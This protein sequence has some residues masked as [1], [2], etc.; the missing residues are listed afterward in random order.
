MLELWWL[1]VS[2]REVSELID[3]F[4]WETPDTSESESRKEK[5][6]DLLTI[7]IPKRTIIEEE[8]EPE[9]QSKRQKTSQPYVSQEASL[10]AETIYAAFNETGLA[11][12]NPMTL[13]EAKR[14]ADWQQWEKAIETE[15]DQLCE[16]EDS[17]FS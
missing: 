7:R 8:D 10:F 15:L 17:Q 4:L 16:T 13:N 2:V 9:R 6:S 5:D 1:E 12:E 3:S 14:S 11:L